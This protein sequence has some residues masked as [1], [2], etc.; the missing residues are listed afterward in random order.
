MQAKERMGASGQTSDRH[1]EGES[2]NNFDSTARLS[3]QFKRNHSII[4]LFVAHAAFMQFVCAFS[5]IPINY[6]FVRC[7][8]LGFGHFVPFFVALIHRFPLIVISLCTFICPWLFV[9]AILFVFAHADKL[10][11]THMH[12]ALAYCC[13][14]KIKSDFLSYKTK[15]K[16]FGPGRNGKTRHFVG[17]LCQWIFHYFVVLML[18]C[19]CISE[20]ARESTS[21]MH[22]FAIRPSRKQENA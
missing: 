19:F 22:Q 9:C 7:C 17:D 3:T 6:L 15:N 18:K 14:A 16:W 21:L 1:W 5:A 2:E 12:T 11:Y 4:H 10:T 8:R 13:F 20:T